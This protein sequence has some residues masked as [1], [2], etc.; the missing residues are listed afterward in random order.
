MIAGYEQGVPGMCVGEKRSL[1]IPPH[2]GYG[3]VGD[4]HFT[5]QLIEIIEEEEEGSQPE[6]PPSEDDDQSE[7]PK[8]E[9]L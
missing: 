7:K 5:I 6:P 3:G 1:T 2:L 8:K 9:E 4:L